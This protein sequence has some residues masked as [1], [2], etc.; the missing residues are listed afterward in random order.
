M[1][2]AECD[3]TAD[4]T[5]VPGKLFSGTVRNTSGNEHRLGL[6]ASSPTGHVLVL[7]LRPPSTACCP[8]PATSSSSSPTGPP[9]TYLISCGYCGSPCTARLLALWSKCLRLRRLRGM[10][11]WRIESRWRLAECIMAVSGFLLLLPP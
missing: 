5:L 7:D 9:Y 8:F 1:T 6:R 3:D 2:D 10:T 11:S 4:P